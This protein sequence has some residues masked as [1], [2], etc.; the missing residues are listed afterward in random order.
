[1]THSNDTRTPINP[2]GLC[3]CGCGEPAPIARQGDSRYGYVKG[4]P[5]RFVYNHHIG[6]PT[7]NADVPPNPAGLCQCGCGQT[8]RI[9]PRTHRPIGWVKGHHVRFI[10]R[11]GARKPG[12]K[13]DVVD[14]GYKTPCHIWNRSLTDG[15]G[16][17]HTCDG[18]RK[19]HVV[20]WESANG[21]VPKGCELDHLCRVRACINPAHL[22]PVSRAVNVQR[23][24]NAKLTPEDVRRIRELA[25]TASHRKIA[26][27]F[28][29]SRAQVGNIVR[30][31]SWKNVP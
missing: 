15:Y 12:P 30:R 10:H 17:V 2:S 24:A 29:I 22:E 9:A 31:E 13:Y 21:P 27:L 6:A 25:Q 28:G 4:Q 1:M 16:G 20:A 23:G 19:A 3:Q 26:P 8:T 14:T 18:V 11:H 5:M 7:S